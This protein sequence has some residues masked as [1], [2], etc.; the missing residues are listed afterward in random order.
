MPFFFGAA[1]VAVTPFR[2]ITTSGSVVL[3]MSYGLPVIAPGV[4]AIR[5]VLGDAADL[6][7]E[8]GEEGLAAALTRAMTDQLDSLRGKTISVC[9]RLDWSLIAHQTAITYRGAVA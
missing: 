4:E 7:Y 9:D 8:P 2:R 5:E 3:A 6:L 1:D